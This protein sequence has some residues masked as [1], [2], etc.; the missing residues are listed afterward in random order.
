M[1][2][3]C[4]LPVPLPLACLQA[5]RKC[6]H[7]PSP[8]SALPAPSFWGTR[9]DVCRRLRG[10]GK[11]TP[12]SGRS[13]G[14]PLPRLVPAR[15]RPRDR[16]QA[17]AGPPLSAAAAHFPPGVSKPRFSAPPGPRP[18]PFPCPALPSG[19]LAPLGPPPSSPPALCTCS[20]A[21]ERARHVTPPNVALCYHVTQVRTR[22]SGV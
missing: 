5:D 11:V 13:R 2:G 14:Q 7:C 10:L 1:G 3:F 21:C 4:F 19:S 6:S 20:A 18:P 8:A 9:A 12:G 15:R 22:R 17:S 16:P